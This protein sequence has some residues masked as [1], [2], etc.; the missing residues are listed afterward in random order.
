M[1]TEEMLNDVLAILRLVKDEK[2]KM[3]KIHDF[4][5]KEVVRF[6]KERDRTAH[7]RKLL[8]QI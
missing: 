8:L 5:M 4:F 7:F 2:E 3:Q 1:K 6:Q